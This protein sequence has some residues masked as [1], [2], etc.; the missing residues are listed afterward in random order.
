MNR[1]SEVGGEGAGPSRHTGGSLSHREHAKRLIRILI[2]IWMLFY[3][4]LTTFF[5]IL[6]FS[7]LGDQVTV[8]ASS[9]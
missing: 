1:M 6:Y 2:K 8:S 3:F 4:S 5:N 7:I 9:T